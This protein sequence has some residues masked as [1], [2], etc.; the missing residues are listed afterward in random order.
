MYIVQEFSA[1]QHKKKYD[2][3]SV[4]QNCRLSVKGTTVYVLK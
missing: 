2:I 3:L 1:V 4:F